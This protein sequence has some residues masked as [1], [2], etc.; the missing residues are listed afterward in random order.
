MEEEE[1]KGSL[2]HR[3]NSPHP[4]PTTT[5]ASTTV[6]RCSPDHLHKQSGLGGLH[7]ILAWADIKSFSKFSGFCVNAKKSATLLKGAW[8]ELHKLQLLSTGLPI[9]NSYKYRG[10]QF[11]AASSEEAYFKKPWGELLLCIPT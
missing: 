2:P 5:S 9:R 7:F 4:P 1:E 8:T 11:E 6:H 10:I 3:I